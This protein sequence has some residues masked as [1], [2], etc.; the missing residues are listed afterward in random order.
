MR[1]LSNVHSA[2]RLKAIVANGF[3]LVGEK[4]QQLILLNAFFPNTSYNPK[5]LFYTQ[6]ETIIKKIDF[7]LKTEIKKEKEFRIQRK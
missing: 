5:P 2:R 7:H 1:D 4:V 3:R 6:P